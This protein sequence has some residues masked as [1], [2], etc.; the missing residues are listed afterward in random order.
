MEKFFTY[1]EFSENELLNIPVSTLAWVGDAV[2]TLCAREFELSKLNSKPNKLH[3]MATTLVNAGAQSDALERILEALNESEQS[4][5]RR[6]RNAPIATKSKHYGI[7]D[8]K[9]ATALE[10]LIGYLY[11]SNKM[12]RLNEILEMIFGETE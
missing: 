12:D 10:A 1:R 11:L 2:Y 7:A 3:K 5:V 9:R 6:A 8:Y 4:V